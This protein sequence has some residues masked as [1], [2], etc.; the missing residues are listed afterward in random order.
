MY[1]GGEGSEKTGL[2]I[3]RSEEAHPK[4]RLSRGE[5]AALPK[6]PGSAPVSRL[7]VRRLDLSP[8]CPVVQMLSPLAQVYS[9]F[10]TL[11]GSV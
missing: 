2:S 4:F 10:A 8:I 5:N 7:A 9:E 3:K 1:E 11:K 6:G